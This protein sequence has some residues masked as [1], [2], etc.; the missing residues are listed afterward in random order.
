MGM[1]SM[2]EAPQQG[3]PAAPQQGMMGGQGTDPTISHGHYNGVVDVEGKPVQVTN[4]VAQVDG[5]P[6][7]V[8]DNGAMVVDS[9]GRLI[10]HIE[11]GKF[12]VVTQEYHDQMMKA[13]YLQ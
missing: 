3:M 13:G 11:N 10:G 12:I 9:Q 6:Y 8:S 4:G 2:P 1:M 5:K 7:V